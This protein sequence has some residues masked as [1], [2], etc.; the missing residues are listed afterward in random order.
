MRLRVVEDEG[1]IRPALARGL[2]PYGHRIGT[3]S[4]LSEARA[5]TAK[6]QPEA[7][8]SDL[9]L[10]DGNGLALALAEE[11]GVPF[12]QMTG[13]GTFD[14]AVRSMR[15]GCHDFFTKPVTIKDVARAAL[16]GGQ[17][18]RGV[19]GLKELLAEPALTARDR[20]NRL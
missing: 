19:Q 8:I 15:L 14:D 9:K 13:Y 17:G 3:A 2:G 1:S 12:L 20:A 4:C 6:R 16:L 11:L 18:E 10:S 5:L 7:L